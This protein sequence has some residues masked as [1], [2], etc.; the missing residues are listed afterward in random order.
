[1]Y[2]KWGQSYVLMVVCAMFKYGRQCKICCCEF[3][4]D[5]SKIARHLKIISIAWVVL[6]FLNHFGNINGGL[7]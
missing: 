7:G 2:F 5:I 3:N 1:M 6:Y 4:A